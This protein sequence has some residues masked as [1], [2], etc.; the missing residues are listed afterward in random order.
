[1]VGK[2]WVL[3][4]AFYGVMGLGIARATDAP[5]APARVIEEIVT[6][7]TPQ[8]FSQQGVLS[9]LDSAV[10]PQKLLVVVSGPPGSPGHV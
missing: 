9:K 5:S 3:A 6:V 10:A 8:G 7:K 1:M 4:L 2:L